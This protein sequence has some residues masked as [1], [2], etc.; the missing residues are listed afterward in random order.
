VIDAFRARFVNADELLTPTRDGHARID[1]QRANR[2]Q[3]ARQASHPNAF[4]PRPSA[5]CA[6]TISSSPTAARKA[7]MVAPGDCSPSSAETMDDSF[8]CSV[9]SFQSKAN[10]SH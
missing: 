10:N 2:Q 3:L 9:L 8:Q 6:A 4:T 1:L 7:S 5:P